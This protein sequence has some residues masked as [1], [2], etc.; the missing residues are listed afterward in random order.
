MKAILQ[1]SERQEMNKLIEKQ[2]R[3]DK[4]KTGQTP[5]DKKRKTDIF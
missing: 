4:S 5:E 3:E 1:F 2:S